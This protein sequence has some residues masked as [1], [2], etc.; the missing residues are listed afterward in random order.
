MTVKCHIK[1]YDIRLNYTQ[2]DNRIITL[3]EYKFYIGNLKFL[4]SDLEQK[5][6]LS[7]YYIKK[8]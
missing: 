7:I 5:F 6:R 1:R 8:I 4:Y 2:T 3:S